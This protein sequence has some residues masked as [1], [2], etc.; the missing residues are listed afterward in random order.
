MNPQGVA[1]R[2]LPMATGARYYKHV[3]VETCGACAPWRGRRA[4]YPLRAF[5]CEFFGGKRPP[6]VFLP[7]SPLRLAWEFRRKTVPRTVFSGRAP[8][9]F[10][11]G[12]SGRKCPP[13]TFEF[14]KLVGERGFEP[15]APASR[16]QCSTRLSY[17]PT[18]AT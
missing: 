14:R 6:D 11:S 12:V 3:A 1:G 18:G 4:P 2:A 5:A 17:S 8:L 9:R 15:P 10:R 16:R 7:E 13:D